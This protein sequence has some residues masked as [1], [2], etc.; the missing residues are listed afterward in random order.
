MK[1]RVFIAKAISSIVNLDR[2]NQLI[3]EIF[4]KYFQPEFYLRN[5]ERTLDNN[6]IHGLTLVLSVLIDKQRVFKFISIEKFLSQIKSISSL[7]QYEFYLLLCNLSIT[8]D[9]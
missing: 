9:L 4:D 2:Y 5:R 6:F 1:T 8:K 3:H 7:R